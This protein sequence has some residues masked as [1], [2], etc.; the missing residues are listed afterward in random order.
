MENE[1]Q[2]IAI[3]KCELKQGLLKQGLTVFMIIF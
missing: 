1:L 2:E 3:L